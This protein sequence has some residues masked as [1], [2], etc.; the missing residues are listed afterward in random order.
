MSQENLRT[1]RRLNAAFSERDWAA[2]ADAL[3]PDIEMDTTRVPFAELARVYHGLDDVAGFWANWLEAWGAVDTADPE[4]IEVGDQVFAW[5]R[6]QTVQGRGSGIEVEMP[7]FG[8]VMTFREGKL[9]RATIYMDRAEALEAA[10][11]SE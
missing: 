7:E 2:A 8:W 10:G 3:H 4:L 1:T 9:V 11:L 6:R 5:A